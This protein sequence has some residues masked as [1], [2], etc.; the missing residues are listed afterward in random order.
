MYTIFKNDTSIILS[1][2]VKLQEQK[3]VRLWNDLNFKGF[4]D[5]KILANEKQIIIYHQ[6]LNELWLGFMDH[7]K[8]IEAAGGI[9]SN[10]ANQLLFIYRLGKWDFPKGKIEQGEGREEAALR[11]VREECGFKQIEL[12]EPLPTSYHIYKEKKRDILKITYWFRMYSDDRDLEPQAAEDITELKW[13]DESLTG[14]VLK[15]TYPSIKLL[16]R[17]YQAGNQ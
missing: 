6:D 7:F 17:A 11:E 14:T 3:G 1:D 8:V 10:K 15:N 9:V 5:H 2:D 4:L 12:G 16:L 13:V